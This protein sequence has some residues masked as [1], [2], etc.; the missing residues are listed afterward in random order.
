MSKVKLQA[1][2]VHTCINMPNSD[3][4]KEYKNNTA[5]KAEFFLVKQIENKQNFISPSYPS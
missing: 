3:N 2:I 4:F 5:F 1:Q